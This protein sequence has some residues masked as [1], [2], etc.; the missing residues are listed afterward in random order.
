MISSMI[1]RNVMRI[2]SVFSISPGA[3][4]LRKELKERTKLNNIPLE[5]GITILLN[6]K[7]LKKNKRYYEL[8]FENKIT[9]NILES[10]SSDQTKFKKIP[11]EIFF[12][13]CELEKILN[14]SKDTKDVYL[15]GSFAKLIYNQN[16]D[17]DI[18]I[19]YQNKINKNNIIKKAAKIE[20]KFSK[21]IQIHFFEKREF[22]KNKK[23]PLIKEII[24]NGILL[25]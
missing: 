10:V 24:R 4:F 7:I 17:V 14:E 21:E 22:D 9:Q 19:I 20:K 25:N 13:L 6:Q 12:L 16:S 23:D 2:L 11:L 1:D 18:A 15:F 8:N 5:S 3:R